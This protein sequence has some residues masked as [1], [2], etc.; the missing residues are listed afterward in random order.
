MDTCIIG[1]M[2][3]IFGFDSWF[4]FWLGYSQLHTGELA[5]EMEA[6]GANDL[7]VSSIHE[8]CTRDHPG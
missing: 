2:L 7:D 8:D 4:T 3:E 5:Q 1:M 6:V